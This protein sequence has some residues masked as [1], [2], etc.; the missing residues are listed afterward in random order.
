MRL[1]DYPTEGMLSSEEFTLDDMLCLIA[2]DNRISRLRILVYDSP[3]PVPRNTYGDFVLEGMEE[4]PVSRDSLRKE[5]NE[6][7]RHAL[8]N[9][10]LVGIASDVV[11]DNG[12][13]AHMPMIDFY[14]KISDD[15][16]KAVRSCVETYK[17]VP[18]FI[19]NSGKS[20]HFYGGRVI[21]KGEWEELT[22]ELMYSDTID[23][24][25][26]DFN[27]TNGYSFLRISTNGD[28]PVMPRVI[29]VL[30]YKPVNYRQQAL[31][32]DIPDRRILER[33]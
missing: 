1:V 33:T 18:G 15:N 10:R 29:E 13:Q 7:R 2:E 11:L 28:K 3:G 25:W 5:L 32:P 22:H 26:G 4:I 16:Q 23:D 31:F 6:A 12:F 20:Y 14:C 30:G 27:L 8:H 17:M 21:H 9:D 24:S 19:L